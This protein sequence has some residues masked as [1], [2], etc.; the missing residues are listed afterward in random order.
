MTL[1]L[2]QA[3]QGIKHILSEMAKELSAPRPQI[4]H[5]VPRIGI[6]T[7]PRNKIRE[8]I[9]SGGKV[10][11]EIVETTGAKIDVEDDGTIKICAAH[12]DTIQ[13]ASD[14]ITSIVASPEIGLI[15]TGKVVKILEFGAFVNFLGNRDGLVHISELVDQ[16]VNRVTDVVRVGEIVKVKVIGFDDRGKVK[17]SMRQVDQKTGADMAKTKPSHA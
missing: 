9:G 4:N 13:Q 3:N 1:A 16:R 7:I 2:H 5:N 8:V 12:N 6:V 11:R 15:Y 14:W 10:I 17:L